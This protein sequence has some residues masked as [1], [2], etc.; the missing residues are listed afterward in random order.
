MYGLHA[1]TEGVRLSIC[2]PDGRREFKLRF[3]A[4]FSHLHL[5]PP[6]LK[7]TLFLLV[8]SK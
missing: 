8:K 2:I 5:H 3:F 6:D 7:D 4:F 1:F